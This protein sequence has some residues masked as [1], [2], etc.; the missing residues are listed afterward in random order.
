MCLAIAS[1]YQGS[2]L[3]SAYLGALVSLRGECEVSA[4]GYLSDL[5]ALCVKCVDVAHRL[6]L[7]CSSNQDY[8]CLI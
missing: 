2:D 1:P 3:V 5:S 6:V 7:L 8:L 4:F